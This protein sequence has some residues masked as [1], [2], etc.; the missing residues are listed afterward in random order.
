MEHKHTIV[1]QFRN[2][3]GAFGLGSLD[4]LDWRHEQEKVF[5]WLLTTANLG[6]CDGGQAGA[7]TM[8][9]FMFVSDIPNAV[10]LIQNYLVDQEYIGF[11]KIASHLED[12][13][14]NWTVHHIG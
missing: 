10:A 3:G 5:D 14:E 7:G 11:S 8:E 9:I 1:V 4:E 12:Q 6:Y 2:S 13:Y